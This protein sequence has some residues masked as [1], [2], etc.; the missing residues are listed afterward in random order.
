MRGT[1]DDELIARH[2]AEKGVTRCPT[3]AVLPTS[4]EIAPGDRARHQA[5]GD[6]PVQP[7]AGR[8]GNPGGGRRAG[9]NSKPMPAPETAAPKPERRDHPTATPAPVV[10]PPAARG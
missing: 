6:N 9:W 3:A 7:L 8:P 10:V 4:A 1:G 5:R 2:I